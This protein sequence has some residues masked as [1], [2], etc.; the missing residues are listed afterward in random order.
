MKIIGV[1]FAGFGLLPFFTTA[2]QQQPDGKIYLQNPSFE[3]T[4]R[5][6]AC[7]WGWASYTPGCTPDIMP[8]AWGVQAKA[9]NGNTCVALVTRDDGSREDIAQQLPQ[10]LKAGTCYT[11]TIYL[12]HSP[13]YVGYN[14]PARLRVWGGAGRGKEQLLTS[15]PL[16][17]HSDWKEYKFQFVPDHDIRYLTLEA[18]FAPGSMFYYRGNILLDNCSPIER[19]DRA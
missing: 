13:D 5:A 10:T 18:Y 14:H 6:S 17:D 1:F 19:C 8:G 3:D 11:F 7:P 12:A 2:D 16:V 4:P 9:Q 15:S